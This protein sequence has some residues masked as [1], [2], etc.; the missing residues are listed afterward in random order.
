[1]TMR[2]ATKRVLGLIPAR[3]GSKGVKNKN[4]RELGG[5][6]LIAYTI[7]TAKKCPLITRLICSTDAPA[8]AEIARSLG[9]EVPFLR[10][11]EL[12]TD[13]APSL[14][15]A[16]HA[17][18]WV[19]KAEG[20]PYD[21]LLLLQPTAPFRSAEDIDQAFK[22]IEKT[23]ADSVVSYVEEKHA[24]PVRMKKMVDGLMQPYCLPEPEGSRRQDFE[25]AYLR[26]GAIYLSKRQIVME[27]HSLYG[28][29]SR[30][31]IM[32]ADRSVNIDE[33]I[34]LQMAAHL[35]VVTRH[36]RGSAL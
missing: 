16:Q 28:K 34:D 12:A 18:A 1:M 32:P 3:S 36:A 19:E 15:V 7:E 35:L 27:Q 2:S 4:I 31:Y 30:P 25:P 17:L 8:I 20:Q 29:N 24:H 5:K 10:P 21:Y 13:I 26:N 22:I 9:A 11:Q 33:E 14:L 23:N 6:P